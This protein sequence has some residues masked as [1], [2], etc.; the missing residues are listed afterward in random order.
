MNYFYLYFLILFATGYSA[1]NPWSYEVIEAG[2]PLFDSAKVSYSPTTGYPPW[3]IEL[4]KTNG[5]IGV[6]LSLVQ[7]HLHPL[8]NEPFKIKLNLSV[9]ERNLEETIPLLEGNM[10]IRF[11]SS[12]ALAFIQSLQDGKKVG[13]LIDGLEETIEPDFFKET[14]SK[15]DKKRFDWLNIQNPI[16]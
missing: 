15:L 16:Q 14:F 7:H 11:P 1:P 12:L 4:I 10:K 9:E 6:Y 3:K 2:D 5:E 13:I 8:P